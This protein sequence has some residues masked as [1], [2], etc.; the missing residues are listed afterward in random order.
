MG[1][2]SSSEVMMMIMTQE[3]ATLTAISP[4]SDARNNTNKKKISQATTVKLGPNRSIHRNKVF[5]LEWVAVTSIHVPQP[6]P[7]QLKYIKAVEI[8]RR[9]S[10]PRIKFLRFTIILA[11]VSLW[12]LL[13][14]ELVA[15][16]VP[17]RLIIR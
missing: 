5:S 13:I 8:C 15:R 1:F 17:A 12:P 9:T 10:E 3:N 11:S 7:P 2:H 6:L 14:I 16:V 4:Q